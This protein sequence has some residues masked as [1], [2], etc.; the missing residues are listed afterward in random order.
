MLKPYILAGEIP[1]FR[2][3]MAMIPEGKLYHNIPILSHH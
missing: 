2:G 3:T 1:M